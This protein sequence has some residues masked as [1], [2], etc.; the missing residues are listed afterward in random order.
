MT[1]VLFFSVSG[2]PPFSGFWPKLMLVKAALAGGDGWLAAAI[3]VGGF[4]TTIATGRFFLIAYW[5]P[6]PPAGENKVGVAPLLPVI[7]LTLASILIG[8]YPEPLIAAA[9]TAAEGLVTPSAY[10]GS[11]FGG[12]P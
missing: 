12:T 4:L 1:L 5:R 7:A 11:V 9:K 8:L 6:A 2:L 3:L 10:I